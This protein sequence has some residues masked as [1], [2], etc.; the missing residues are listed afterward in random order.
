MNSPGL[1][2][3]IRAAVGEHARALTDQQLATAGFVAVD[4]L[5]KGVVALRR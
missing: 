3:A 4:D 2:M 1:F 5:Y